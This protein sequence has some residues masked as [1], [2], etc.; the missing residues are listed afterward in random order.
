[1]RHRW[2]IASCVILCGLTGCNQQRSGGGGQPA[3]ST[4]A[5]P[6]AAGP[7]AEDQQIE[8]LIAGKDPDG[9]KAV[10]VDE[11]FA[12]LGQGMMIWKGDVEWFKK[13]AADSKAAGSPAMYAVVGDA[14]GAQVAAQYVIVMPADP[15]ARRKVI[16][17]YN[18]FWK[19]DWDQLE[20]EEQE[21]LKS[22]FVQDR[23][24]KYLMLSYD[25]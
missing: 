17:A 25:P 14:F 4:S 22:E 9:D 23:G 13:L 12:K 11:F 20:P 8:L 2:L 3:A 10:P 18:N 24:Q 16:E 1:M 19:T 21:E 7:N 6:A 15:A 5:Q